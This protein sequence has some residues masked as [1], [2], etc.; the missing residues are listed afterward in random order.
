MKLYSVCQVI[1]NAQDEGNIPIAIMNNIEINE[2]VFMSQVQSNV[3]YEDKISEII[4]NNIKIN[5]FPYTVN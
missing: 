3:Q 1:S 2:N 5:D 4:T